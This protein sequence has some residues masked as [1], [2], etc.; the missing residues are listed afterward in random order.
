MS[1]TGYH[2]ATQCYGSKTPN[3]GHAVDFVLGMSPFSLDKYQPYRSSFRLSVG[4]SDSLVFITQ[5]K[6]QTSLLA[7]E[8]QF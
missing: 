6:N 1:F 3:Q 7:E 4:S 5:I 2:S 8:S